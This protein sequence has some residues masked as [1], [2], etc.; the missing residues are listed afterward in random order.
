LLCLI[1]KRGS[2]SLFFNLVGFVVFYFICRH[3]RT[4]ASAALSL[5][6]L[7]GIGV[8][9]TACGESTLQKKTTQVPMLDTVKTIIQQSSTWQWGKQQSHAMKQ[10]LRL[11][12]APLLRPLFQYPPAGS[13]KIRRRTWS[14][15]PFLDASIVNALAL[16]ATSEAPIRPPLEG[17]SRVYAYN[18]KRSQDARVFPA[19][20]GIFR[21]S[22]L[23]QEPEWVKAWLG[24]HQHKESFQQA[25]KE[26][27]LSERSLPLSTWYTLIQGQLPLALQRQIP[28]HILNKAK[29]N[30]L[31]ILGWQLTTLGDYP[32]HRLLLSPE[33]GKV[34]TRG[35]AFAWAVYIAHLSDE[36][37]NAEEDTC[38]T[39]YC[40]DEWYAPTSASP[41]A[42]LSQAHDWGELS[43]FAQRESLV[44]Y[45]HGVMTAV[46]EDP[47]PSDADALSRWKIDEASPLT[48]L[49]ALRLLAWVEQE[50]KEH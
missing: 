49:E 46:L 27:T 18:P 6:L 26:V 15:A 45:H 37:Q 25:L 10:D 43:F 33:K 28:L 5:F 19:Y 24:H 34:L 36:L 2:V 7:L 14:N 40:A 39:E 20:Q 48:P 30:P 31:E 1:R 38:T 50:R 44:A 13:A 3:I 47:P 22:L 12:I 21:Q 8:T 42:R 35:Q 29:Q 41:D 9:L 23:E 4:L 17:M 11:W 16:E 32:L